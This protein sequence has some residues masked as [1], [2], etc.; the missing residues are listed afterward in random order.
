VPYDT[1]VKILSFYFAY[2][3]IMM[4]SVIYDQFLGVYDD[5]FWF[6]RE[7]QHIALAVSSIV[8]MSQP[9]VH[10]VSSRLI[11]P[12]ASPFSIHTDVCEINESCE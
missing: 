2:G 6:V 7:V 5:M 12:H 3:L 9:P 4:F 1:V 8:I 10:D 11:G